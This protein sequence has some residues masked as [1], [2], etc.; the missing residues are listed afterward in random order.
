MSTPWSTNPAWDVMMQS[1]ETA[2]CPLRLH[3]QP[4]T[5]DQVTAAVA[6]DQRC[7]GGMWG[8]DGYLREIESP[9]GLLLGLTAQKTHPNAPSELIGLGCLWMVLDEA[10]ITVLVVDA[11]YRQAGLG[12][13]LLCALLAQ[14]QQRGMHRATLEVRASNERAIALYTA[15]GFQTVGQRKA[16][17]N[18][19]IEDACI[20]WLRDLQSEAFLK[21]LANWQQAAS[22]RRHRRNWELTCNLP[23]ADPVV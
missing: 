20:L 13:T 12:Q 9:N 6:L 22:D 16:Y 10:H 18:H 7:L 14:A 3:L 8:P 2:N 5:P 23:T 15:F 19:P 21:N 4:L 1:H 11:P 17:Y